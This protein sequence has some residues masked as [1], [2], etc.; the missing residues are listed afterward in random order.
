MTVIPALWRPGNC[1]FEVILVCVALS[2]KQNEKLFSLHY[3]FH[4]IFLFVFWEKFRESEEP[5]NSS[6]TI[7]WPWESNLHASISQVLGLKIYTNHHTWPPDNCE[8]GLS[9]FYQNLKLSFWDMWGKVVGVVI[10]IFFPETE[11]IALACLKPTHT[12]LPDSDPL[13]SVSR[14]LRL[15]CMSHHIQPKSFHVTGSS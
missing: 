3:F 14:M 2:P 6:S 8:W 7:G 4:F 12:W 11:S 9:F 10:C 1:E 15:I 13:F 5:S